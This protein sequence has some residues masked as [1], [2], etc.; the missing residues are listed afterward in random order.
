M[1]HIET[2]LVKHRFNYIE[3]CKV[4]QGKYAIFLVFMRI[5]ST[6]TSVPTFGFPLASIFSSGWVANSYLQGV[7][8][9]I[10]KILSIFVLFL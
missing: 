6:N 10:N 7:I 3:H 5:F 9:Y 4:R 1:K 8:L 2:I